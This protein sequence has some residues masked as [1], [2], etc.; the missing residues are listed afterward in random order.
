MKST[1]RD[2]KH[3]SS[4]FIKLALKQ[5]QNLPRVMGIQAV[6][7]NINV[8]LFVYSEFTITI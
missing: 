2:P 7:I 1:K 6:V 3:Y 5:S 4:L 8:N